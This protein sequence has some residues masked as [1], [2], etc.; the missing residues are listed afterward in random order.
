MNTL[1]SSRLP[2]DIVSGIDTI[3]KITNRSRSFHIKK[4]L[5]MYLINLPDIK[6]PTIE[7]ELNDAFSELNLALKNKQNLAKLKTLDSLINELKH[8]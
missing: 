8:T 6:E 5:E 1:V 4:A 2:Q 3:A 7:N